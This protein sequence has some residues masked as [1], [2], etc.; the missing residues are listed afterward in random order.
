MR[1]GETLRLCRNAMPVEQCKNYKQL[2]V[3]HL[4]EMRFSLRRFALLN[5]TDA[6]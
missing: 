2:P 1:N 3:V 6:S 5:A 4:E